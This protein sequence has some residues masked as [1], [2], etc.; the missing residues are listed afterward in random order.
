[1][2]NLTVM[3]ILETSNFTFYAFAESEQHAIEL[4]EKRWI[5]HQKK[6]GATYTFS[7]LLD[8]VFFTAIQAGAYER[9][10][11]PEPKKTKGN[12]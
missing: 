10:Q 5:L 12:K 1:M 11:L 4:L 3:A 7:E 8:D 9:S 6:M 2:N